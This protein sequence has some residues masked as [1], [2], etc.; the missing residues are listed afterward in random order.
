[1]CSSFASTHIFREKQRPEGQ[2][3][4]RCTGL[5]SHKT[6]ISAQLL[7][8]QQLLQEQRSLNR[9]NLTITV[10][11]A[12]TGFPVL[13]LGYKSGITMCD[14]IVVS[15]PRCHRGDPG[16][17]PGRADHLLV[18][19]FISERAKATPRAVR[20]VLAKSTRTHRFS[21]SVV[22]YD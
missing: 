9:A 15:I 19:F 18:L 21:S 14:S 4:E 17:I 11:P 5:Y 8:L 3:A 7:Q 12:H 13:S 20:R 2:I 16:S 10:S 22:V 6:I 1:M